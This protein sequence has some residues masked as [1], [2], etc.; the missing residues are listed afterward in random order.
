MFDI[1]DKVEGTPVH[2]KLKGIKKLISQY[3][4]ESAAEE[5]QPVIEQIQA[6]VDHD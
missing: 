5:L 2:G 3:D 1:L 4:L 6:E